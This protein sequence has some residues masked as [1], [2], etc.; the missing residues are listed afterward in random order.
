MKTAVC[1]CVCDLFLISAAVVVAVVVVAA[2]V[3]ILVDAAGCADAAATAAATAIAAVIAAAATAIAAATASAAVMSNGL[4]QLF[5]LPIL[6]KTGLLRPTIGL[7]EVSIL[8][9]QRQLLIHQLVITVVLQWLW[10]T[11]FGHRNKIEIALLISRAN[12]AE[13]VA[14]RMVINP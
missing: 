7:M 5:S 3:A 14:I 13:M 10:P 2:F 11:G 12:T 6:L 9:Q 4:H 1:M 8:F